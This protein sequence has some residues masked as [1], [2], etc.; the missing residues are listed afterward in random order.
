MIIHILKT[1]H[2]HRIFGEILLNLG[3][4]TDSFSQVKKHSQTSSPV[5]L[6]NF[7]KLKTKLIITL[8]HRLYNCFFLFLIPNLI[9]I[10]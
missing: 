7:R 6:N 8:N 5:S 1:A 3:C 9:Y 10:I 4:K 2:L